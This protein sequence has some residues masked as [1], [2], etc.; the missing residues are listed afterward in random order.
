M[1]LFDDDFFKTTRLLSQHFVKEFSESVKPLNALLNNFATGLVK[2]D[3]SNIYQN[4]KEFGEILKS[5]ENDAINY[6]SIIV[7]LGYPPH[8]EF[9]LQYMQM[10]VSDYNEFGKDYASNHIDDL[11]FDYYNE[12]RISKI[13]N[14]WEENKL[15]KERIHILRNVIKCHNQMMYNAVIP[16][17]IPQ[18]EGVIAEAFKHK[19]KFNGFHMNIYLKNLLIKNSS[20]DSF[21]LE[22]ALYNFYIQYLLVGFNHGDKIAS[23]VSRNAILHGAVKNYGEK[24]NSL[25]LIL[26]FDFLIKI[27]SN[28]P[29]EV[30][31]SARMEIEEIKAQKEERERQNYERLK[32]KFG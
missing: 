19:G 5:L 16:T 25:K 30:I 9:P 27:L 14:K 2:Y 11:M 22:D 31:H 10:I 12:Q 29:T 26:L 21:S 6:K 24:S 28:V 23:E 20:G 13:E 3:F 8:E 17:I 15:A 7:E 1:R 32:K 4:F 18:L